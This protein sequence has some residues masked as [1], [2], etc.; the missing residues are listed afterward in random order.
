MLLISVYGYLQIRASRSYHGQVAKNA[1]VVYKL[2]VDGLLKIMAI[3]FMSHPGDYLKS[4]E[5][6]EPG[7]DFTFPGNIFAYSLKTKASSTL[8]S[9]LALTDT[10]GLKTYLK[11]VLKIRDFEVIGLEDTTGGA[12]NGAGK[13]VGRS[14]DQKITVVYDEKMLAIAYSLKREALMEELTD[15]LQHRNRMEDTAPLMA[16][17]KKATGHLSWTTAGTAGQLNFKD[18]QV[19][20]EGRFPTE[21]LDIP[22]HPHPSVQFADHALLKIWLN[23]GFKA[24][25]KPN[26][27]ATNKV[28][29]MLK[30]SVFFKELSLKGISIEPDTLLKSYQG[31]VALEMG[32]GITQMDSLIAYEYNDDFEKVAT[33]QMKKVTVPHLKLSITAAGKDLLSYLSANRVIGQDN[34]LNKQIFPLYQVFSSQQDQIWQLS[35]LNNDPI[36]LLTPSTSASTTAS[37]PDFFALTAD[38]KGIKTQQLFPLLNSWLKPFSHLKITA[39]KGEVGTA[40]I[41]GKLEFE[42]KN[43][44]AFIQLIR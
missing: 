44:N 29:G 19:E 34:R 40:R 10:T 25:S 33:V 11:R 1:S 14:A 4:K 36:R 13:T 27:V 43:R 26:E 12:I 20:M 37:N 32:P 3:D 42:D 5:K 28:S 30:G 17:V 8:F 39:A 35:T 6:G 9:G 24:S 38:L 21:G 18:G 22:V 16:A 41:N 2:N 23:A 7:P 15:I 31:F